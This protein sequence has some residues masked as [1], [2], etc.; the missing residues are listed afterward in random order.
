MNTKRTPSRLREDHENAFTRIE[1]LALLIVLALLASIALPA[2]GISASGSRFVQCLNN[3]RLVGR[4]VHGW[5]SNYQNDPPWVAYVSDGGTRPEGS[6]TKPGNAWF[7]FT[8][9]SNELVTPRILACPADSEAR[10]ASE[11]SVSAN[12]GYMA[13]G[14]RGLATSYFINLHTSF[15]PGGTAALRGNPRA[16]LC[17]DRNVFFPSVASCALGIAAVDSIP[18]NDPSLRWTNAVHGVQGNLLLFDGSVAPTTSEDLRKAFRS[19]GGDNSTWHL[20]R[21]R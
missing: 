21:A 10:V 1:L 15:N 12:G 19:S 2:I 20:L 17:G 16:P 5:G 13:T 18:I 6:G 4:A 14:Y 9:L 8:A 7:E 11:F 3:L